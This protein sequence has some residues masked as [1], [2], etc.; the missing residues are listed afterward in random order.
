MSISYTAFN[1]IQ[2]YNDDVM[3]LYAQWDSPTVIVCDG[4]YGV[5][6]SMTFPV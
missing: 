1:Q 6:V 5:K 4:L 3:N 2:L